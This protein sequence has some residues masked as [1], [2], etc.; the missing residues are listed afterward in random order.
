MSIIVFSPIYFFAV[1]LN[2]CSVA[3]L[4]FPLLSLP[5]LFLFD[6]S[7]QPDEM[8]SQSVGL[9]VSDRLY[10]AA[11]Q[12]PF[13]RPSHGN[14]HHPSPSPDSSPSS[15]SQF[16]YLG[17][18]FTRQRPPPIHPIPTGCRTRTQRCSFL[19]CPCKMEF[20]NQKFC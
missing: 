4:P 15:H 5:P 12:H 8:A 6:P 3:S 16:V 10:T 19:F 7:Q 17:A 14:H 9:I 1:W 2:L 18:G 13:Y 20:S 11:D